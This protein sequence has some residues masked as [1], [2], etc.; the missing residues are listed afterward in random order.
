MPLSNLINGS[1]VGAVTSGVGALLGNNA[2]TNTQNAGAQMFNNA[3]LR[4]ETV[5]NPF[6]NA[7]Y[8]ANTG[9]NI[10]PTGS[11]GGANSGLQAMANAGT[12]IANRFLQ[13]GVPA[14]VTNAG[15][16]SQNSILA[17]IAALMNGQG[18]ANSLIRAGTNQLNNPLIGLAQ[19][20]AGSNIL[21]AGQDF[22]SV[23]NTQLQSLMKQL[24]LPQQLQM[25]ANQQGQF[26]RGQLGTTGGALQTQA[27]AT[28]FGQA[29]LAAQQQAFQQALAAQGQATSSAGVLGTL[30]SNQ[31][32]TGGNLIGTGSNALTAMGGLVGNLATTGLQ[33]S[34]YAAAA[35]A[36]LA[37]AFNSN[38]V[39]PALQ[40][41]TAINQMGL[42]S[43]LLGLN[44]GNVAGNLN[45]GAGRGL[46]E[47]GTSNNNSQSNLANILSAISGGGNSSLLNSIF[48][49]AK[50]VFGGGSDALTTAANGAIG[51]LGNS[52]AFGG[53]GM[54]TLTNDQIAAI[55]S[56]G[57]DLNSLIDS[58]LGGP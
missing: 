30:A 49:G 3:P 36:T 50:S 18:G 8:N 27:L 42:N 33:N 15:N 56:Q 2:Q 24:Q 48:S 19:G 25:N 31:Q 16:V 53:L 45:I 40:G 1:T 34:I 9:W 6:G 39:N 7:T 29:D 46:T 13:G 4:N 5:S 14:S 20:A 22:N 47:L 38:V 11:L 10:N 58:F 54:D 17:Q 51:S 21:Q 28:G 55:G 43:A 44:T 23:Y 12:G 52:P 26:S 35:P 37:G 41:T 57:P 32:L